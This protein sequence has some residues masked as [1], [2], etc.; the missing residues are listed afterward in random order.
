MGGHV[1]PASHLGAQPARQLTPKSGASSRGAA[2]S[3]C[4]LLPQSLNHCNKMV[5]P[6]GLEGIGLSAE[7]IARCRQLVLQVGGPGREAR[8]LQLAPWL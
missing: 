6:A 3:P 1:C 8:Q 2:R 4:C 5:L 7:A